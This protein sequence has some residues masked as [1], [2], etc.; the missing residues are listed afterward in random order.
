MPQIEYEDKVVEVPVAKHVRVPMIQK[1]RG[2]VERQSTR[3]RA[4]AEVQKI[5]DVPQIE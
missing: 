5:V 2:A 3:W 1:A 4:L